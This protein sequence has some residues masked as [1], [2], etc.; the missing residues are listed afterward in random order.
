MMDKAKCIVNKF[1]R[2]PME[3]TCWHVRGQW[4]TSP[5]L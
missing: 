2:E 4:R 3:S 1:N 5:Y